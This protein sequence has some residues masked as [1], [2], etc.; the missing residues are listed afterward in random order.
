MQA[1]FAAV[2]LWDV[3]HRPVIVMGARHHGPSVTYGRLTLSDLELQVAPALWIVVYLALVLGRW[4]LARWFALAAGAQIVYALSVT[5]EPLADV[6]Y[7]VAAAV[8]LGMLP[9]V[10]IMAAFH[11]DAPPVPRT[12]PLIALPVGATLIGLWTHLTGPGEFATFGVP[13]LPAIY[14]WPFLAAC[15]GYV[16]T[17]KATGRLQA[18][19]WPLGLALLGVPILA[20]RVL[21]LA[22]YLGQQTVAP[23]G[24][25]RAVITIAVVQAVLVGLATVAMVVTAI[26]GM[27]RLPAGAATASQG[28]RPALP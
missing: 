24:W 5:P 1:I 16:I 23:P 25:L 2:M 7:A 4:R 12:W 8:G 10:A 3:L 18:P 19:C 27:R 22:V 26:C 9:A 15:A 20:A 13:D 11:Q 28:P 21:A 17:R 6:P 14:C